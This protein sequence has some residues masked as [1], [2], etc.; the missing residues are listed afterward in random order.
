MVFEE[1]KTKSKAGKTPPDVLL[2][3]IAHS[4]SI[5]LSSSTTGA[6]WLNSSVSD[7]MCDNTPLCC[8]NTYSLI[9]CY[10]GRLNCISGMTL[11]MMMPW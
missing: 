4:I 8:I 2:P 3:Q 9:H 11:S 6:C 5:F 1:Y 10:T 7:S